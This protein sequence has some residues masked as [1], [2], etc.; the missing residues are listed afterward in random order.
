VTA[1]TTAALAA[2]LAKVQA[3]LPKLER[4]RTVTVQ[5]KN[6]DTYSYSYATLANLSETVL[7]LLASHGLS[8]VAMPGAGSDGK[9]CVR[10]Q[11]L[12]ESGESLAGEFPISGEGGIQ[13]IGGRIT[14]ARRYCLAALVGVAA[15]E[16]DE[17]RLADEGRP[18]TA[19]RAAPRG[20]Q[21]PRPAAEAQEDRPTAQRAQRRSSGPPL[22]GEQ[23][24]GEAPRD[25]ITEKQL[26]MLHVLFG[27]VDMPTR[28]ER[29]QYCN[30]VLAGL[31]EPREVTSSTMLTK[32]EAT[33]II[34]KLKGW[35]DQL[36]PDGG[37]S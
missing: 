26:K 20:R 15:D 25:A 10:Y 29:L 2:A 13:M 8:F 28:E 30:E 9:M 19:Q 37:G 32:T 24:G 17:S 23:E 27:K 21:A 34:D 11:L 1:P 6:G 4:D 12:H 22:P 18:A 36:E 7:P 14:Y 31:E 3:Q 16:D 5:Q 33:A 35:A